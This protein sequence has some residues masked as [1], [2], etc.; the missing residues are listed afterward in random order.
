MRYPPPANE[1][2]FEEFCLLYYRRAWNSPSLN[3]FGRRGQ[4]QYGIDLLETKAEQ[5]RRAIQ[6]KLHLTGSPLSSAELRIEVEKARQFSERIDEYHFVTTAPR[7]TKVQQEL[8]KIAEEQEKAGGFRVILRTW[9]DFER[10]FDNELGAADLLPG[11]T[12]ATSTRVL[13]DR[14]QHAIDESVLVHGTAMHDAD[15]DEARDLLRCGEFAAA[16]QRLERK[17]SHDW[18][19]LGPRQR[20]RVLAN[21]G[22]AY[23]HLDKPS[24][25]AALYLQAASHQPDDPDARAYSAMGHDLLGQRAEAYAIASELV[26]KHRCKRAASVFVRSAPPSEPASSL[27][28]LV[29]EWLDEVDV[30]ISLIVRAINEREYE[31]GL[32]LALRLDAKHPEQPYG[33]LFAGKAVLM[34]QQVQFHVAH[35]SE[36]REVDRA[37]LERAEKFLTEGIARCRTPELTQAKG[38]GLLDRGQVRSLLRKKNERQD[39]LEEASRLIPNNPDV[40]ILR[41]GPLIEHDRPAGIGLLREA[42]RRARD[43]RASM[44]LASELAREAATR[45]E[46]AEIYLR[47]AATPSSLRE[48]ALIQAVET[49]LEEKRFSDA[50]AA[51]DNCRDLGESVPRILRALIAAMRGDRDEAWR[52]ASGALTCLQS[53]E[54]ATVRRMLAKILTD[55]EEYEAALRLWQRLAVP[56]VDTPDTRLLI[57]CA[58]HLGDHALVIEHCRRLRENGVVL[59]KLIVLEAGLLQFSDPEKCYTVLSGYIAGHPD[60][61]DA[62]L[63]LS[64]AALRLGRLQEVVTTTARLPLPSGSLEAAGH[65]INLLRAL[66]LHD[67]AL[68]YAYEVLRAHWEEADAHRAFAV[69]ALGAPLDRRPPEPATV[70]PGTAVRFKELP[71]GPERWLVIEDGPTVHA[72]LDE[73]RSDTKRAAPFLGRRVGEDIVLAHGVQDREAKILEVVSKYTYRVRDVMEE[74]QVRFPDRHDLQAMAIGPEELPPEKRFEALLKV[75]DDRATHARQV[76]ATYETGHVPLS[77]LSGALGQDPMT[78]QVLL[79]TDATTKI[80]AADGN[81]RAYEAAVQ[82]AATR[83]TIVLDISAVT[84]IVLLGL[85]DQVEKWGWKLAMTYSTRDMVRGFAKAKAQRREVS[86][87]GRGP[88]G[89]SVS[90][91]DVERWARLGEDAE[92]LLAKCGSVPAPRLATLSAEERGQLVDLYG[93][94]GA[95]TIA[96]GVDSDR[97]VWSDDVTVIFATRQQ[98]AVGV[99]TQGLLD[100]AVTKSSETSERADEIGA[101]LVGYDYQGMWLRPGVTA[102]ACRLSDCDPGKGPL[103]SFVALLRNDGFDLRAAAQAAVIILKNVYQL[104]VIPERRATF[105]TAILEALGARKD[106]PLAIAILRRALRTAF[107]VNVLASVDAEDLVNA[108]WQQR[109]TQR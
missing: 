53:D 108:W 37:A 83:G 14:L 30:L 94:W 5:P 6:C 109:G 49:L 79:A 40:L 102:A 88:E 23:V 9:E 68:K 65:T 15:I 26:T 28:A 89:I 25:G 21:L 107:G 73:A 43:D 36:P 27:G 61:R 34:A 51:V 101:T 75:S 52:L 12:V 96:A 18:D 4:R 82:E 48:D 97:V 57:E 60:D 69:L 77:V 42:V 7:D 90:V 33:P 86:T 81:Q 45:A 106:A 19:K 91:V 85:V 70:A 98:G 76:L 62:T 47:I 84:T 72:S 2:A 20:F 50:Q 17:K 54:P 103:R 80:L 92:R 56:G 59:A 16:R 100:A 71:D 38:E 64:M 1:D 32:E 93:Q 99:G 10:D 3:R 105:A 104:V 46:A 58:Y 55:L 66:D 11:P 29:R 67:D 74:F 35:R 31:Y 24:E 22:T 78:C 8:M 13:A 39:D 63:R 44:F 95:E 87:V 41:A